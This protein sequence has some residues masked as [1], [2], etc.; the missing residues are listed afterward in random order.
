MQYLASPAPDVWWQTSYREEELQSGNPLRARQP[1]DPSDETGSMLSV[2]WEE[3]LFEFSSSSCFLSLR[4]LHG[5][6][7]H[8]AFTTFVQSEAYP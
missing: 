6:Q 5:G 7:I 8:P 1:K 3:W 2:D 4:G